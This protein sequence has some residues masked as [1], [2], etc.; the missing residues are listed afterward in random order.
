MQIMELRL[1]KIT[2]QLASQEETNSALWEATRKYRD[3]IRYIA[4][5]PEYDQD[6]AQRLRDIAANFLRS[7]PEDKNPVTVEENEDQQPELFD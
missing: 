1:N 5:M 6:D 7:T 4:N 2:E 3:F